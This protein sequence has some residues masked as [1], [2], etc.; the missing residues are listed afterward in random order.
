MEKVDI[1]CKIGSFSFGGSG[2]FFT[3]LNKERN[4]DDYKEISKEDIRF[5]LF[6]IDVI[7]QDPASI[8]SKEIEDLKFLF[9]ILKEK[10]KDK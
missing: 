4:F 3:W 9:Y 6:D 5:I 10:E 1:S 2:I 7:F 8:R